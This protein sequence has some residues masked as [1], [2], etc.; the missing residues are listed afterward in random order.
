MIHKPRWLAFTK[1]DLLEPEEAKA[2]AEK[3]IEELAWESPWALISS[4]THSGTM[5]LMQQIMFSIEE[6]DEIAG[7]NEKAAVVQEFEMP[8]T[9]PDM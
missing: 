9:P 8:E 4:V 1:T 6:M 5:E 7:M 3:I 2:R